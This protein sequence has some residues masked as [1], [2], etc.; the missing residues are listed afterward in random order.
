[1]SCCGGNSFANLRQSWTPQASLNLGRW[2]P[3]PELQAPTDCYGTKENYTDCAGCAVYNGMPKQINR[4]VAP[5]LTNSIRLD[6]N[7]LS[8]VSPQQYRAEMAARMNGRVME[9]YNNMPNCCTSDTM[10]YRFLNGTWD[11]QNRYSL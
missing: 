6:N 11:V 2:D 8:I 4:P 1:M 3:Y 9:G 7:R 5:S 10:P